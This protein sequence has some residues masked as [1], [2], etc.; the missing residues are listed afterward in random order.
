MKSKVC[1]IYDSK[2]DAWMRPFVAQS[3]NAAIRSFGDEVNSSSRDSMVAAHPE[4]YCL[5]EL[6]EWDERDGKLEVYSSPRS[7]GLGVNFKRDA[8]VVKAV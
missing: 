1:S 4:D 3:T 7:L 2:A 5:Y 6:G 8:Q